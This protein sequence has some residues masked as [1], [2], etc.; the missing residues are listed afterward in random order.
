[1]TEAALKK[2][3]WT[4]CEKAGFQP[5]DW[6]AD[7]GHRVL[8][9]RLWVYL[10]GYTE[11]ETVRIEAVC[12]RVPREEQ[13]QGLWRFLLAR[14]AVCQFCRYFIIEHDE[15]WGVRVCADLKLSGL[16]AGELAEHIHRVARTAFA[17]SRFRSRFRPGNCFQCIDASDCSEMESLLEEA[18]LSQHCGYCHQL[19]RVSV[20][21]LKCESG[22]ASKWSK[23]GGTPDLA[24]VEAPAAE[25]SK[26][27]R[28]L[29]QIDF[30]QLP[31]C[32]T[33]PFPDTGLLSLFYLHDEEDDVFWGEPGFVKAVFRPEPVFL[34]AQ[35]KDGIPIEFR[36]SWE[37]PQ[38]MH[39]SP[40]R[41]LDR[42]EEYS[43]EDS[44]N[45]NARGLPADH[46]LGYARHGT[47]VYNPTPEGD[48]IPL[49]GLSSHEELEWCWN[50][51]DS[52]TVFI[53]RRRLAERDFS[54]LSVT[55]G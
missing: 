38:D 9:H 27:Y 44:V 22:T 4:L 6:G 54:Q 36:L 14:N 18:E 42:D 3:L 16:K 31:E 20:E 30:A 53:E 47:I 48:W 39:Q 43:Y 10:A 34:G 41:F 50:D 23:L 24:Q 49:L 29:A 19:V 35:P 13:A 8:Y 12:D 40:E 37:L 45:W 52:L 51:G 55:A 46:L 15:A 33:S 2:K 17:Y 28:L 21:I 5:F 26:S 25:G 7:C 1:M 32:P 11:D